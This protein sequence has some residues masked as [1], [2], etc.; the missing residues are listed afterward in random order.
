MISSMPPISITRS[1]FDSRPVV[2]VSKMIS[3]IHLSG[4]RLSGQFLQN[5]SYLIPCRFDTISGI[6]DKIGTPALFGVGHLP[7]EDHFEF[8]FR[9]SRS[10]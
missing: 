5:L 1:S 10:G 8:L 2:S 6:D 7:G 3:R 4:A 9:H